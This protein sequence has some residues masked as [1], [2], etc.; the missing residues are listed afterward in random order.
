MKKSDHYTL[1][2]SQIK[3]GIKKSLSASH[4]MAGYAKDM[5]ERNANPVLAFGLYAFALEEYGKS[6]LIRNCMDIEMKRYQVPKVIF[7]GK[8][9]HFKKIQ[10][11]LDDLPSNCISFD[12][13]D[14]KTSVSFKDDPKKFLTDIQSKT[15]CFCLNWNE[16][17]ETWDLPPKI[18]A[19]DMLNSILEF[20]KYV[21]SKLDSEYA[22]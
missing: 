8:E 5:L 17:K 10:K 1:T 11:A 12:I 20:E 21:S 16:V 9:S 4:E 18:I 15:S 14:S 7:D 13:D 6:E 22:N 19:E 2:K 3:T